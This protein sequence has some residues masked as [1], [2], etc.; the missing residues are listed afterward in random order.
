MKLRS[1]RGDILT[2]QKNISLGFP[3]YQKLTAVRH[4]NRRDYW[5]VTQK[6]NS[7]SL[8]SYLNF[9]KW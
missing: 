1:G 7:D 6:Y 5:V 3:V 2:S 4:A 8:Y 9:T